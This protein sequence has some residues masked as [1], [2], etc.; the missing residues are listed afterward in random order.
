MPVCIEDRPTILQAMQ[1]S[2]ERILHT[3]PARRSKGNRRSS[4]C[5]LGARADVAVVCLGEAHIRN[6]GNITDLTLGKAQ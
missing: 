1:G 4:G 6:S 3:F 5:A 2:L